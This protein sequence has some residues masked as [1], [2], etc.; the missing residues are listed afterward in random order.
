[1]PLAGLPWWQRMLL[2]FGL[3]I[4]WAISL[5]IVGDWGFASQYFWFSA[6]VA[7][8]GFAVAPF[9]RLKASSW[10]WLT[11]LFLAVSHLVALYFERSF[12]AEPHLPPKGIFQ[13]LFLA[14]VMA[15]WAVMV[16][17]CWTVTRQFPWNITEE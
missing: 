9:W 1:M 17:I 8:I 4:L 10:Y 3:I 6:C 13:M 16:G 15:S 2:T 14:D 12:I 11:I 5:F 7:A